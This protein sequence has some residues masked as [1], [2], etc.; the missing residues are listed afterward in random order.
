MAKPLDQKKPLSVGE[1]KSQEEKNILADFINSDDTKENNLHENASAASDKDGEAS[2]SL[3]LKTEAELNDKLDLGEETSPSEQV[4]EKLK[5]VP[6][7]Y[8]KHQTV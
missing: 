3:D 1:N 4:P 8:W 7:K 5:D 6:R 2:A